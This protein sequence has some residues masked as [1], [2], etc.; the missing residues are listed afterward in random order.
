[1]G[2]YIIPFGKYRGIE[3]KNVKS[4]Y[5]KYLCDICIKAYK[6]SSEIKKCS[7]AEIFIDDIEYFLFW[8]AGEDVAESER[9][10]AIKILNEIGD[11]KRKKDIAIIIM[12]YQK[13]IEKLIEILDD[14][15][16]KLLERDINLYN[17][18]F[19]KIYLYAFQRKTIK[20]TRKY[21][22][23]NKICL[24]CFRK[25]VPIGIARR[26]GGWGVDWDTRR[27]HKK[28]FKEIFA[29]N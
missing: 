6:S 18:N 24:Y 4:D 23:E 29:E 28:C 19:S 8:A 20:M 17:V 15:A 7:S 27:F 14:L 13:Q 16:Q 5:L 25:L 11:D 1:M 10:I 3:L 21:C 26:N 9:N 2:D 22:H 12:K